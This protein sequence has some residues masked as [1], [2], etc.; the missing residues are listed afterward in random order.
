MN[1][2]GHL[3]VFYRRRLSALMGM[4]VRKQMYV[5]EGVIAGHFVFLLVEAVV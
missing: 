5:V 2:L 3:R 4:A 1:E